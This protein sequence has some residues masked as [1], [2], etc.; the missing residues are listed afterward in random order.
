MRASLF[1]QICRSVRRG[2][3]LC[4]LGQVTAVA[5]AWLSWLSVSAVHGGQIVVRLACEQPG[6]LHAIVTMTRQQDAACAGV[7]GG[8]TLSGRIHCPDDRTGMERG[9]RFAACVTASA[10]GGTLA[11]EGG[12]LCIQGARSAVLLIAGFAVN[13]SGAAIPPVAAM[14]AL[15]LLLAVSLRAGGPTAERRPRQQRGERVRDT[16]APPT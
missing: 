11:S 12:A 5:F 10:P 9:L 1:R 2:R 8:L 15:P 3:S 13:D 16:A 6:S 14:L 4:G 7:P